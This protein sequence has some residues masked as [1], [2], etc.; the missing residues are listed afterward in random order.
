MSAVLTPSRAI[1]RE[2]AQV[3]VAKLRKVAAE[4]LGALVFGATAKDRDVLRDILSAWRYA[5]ST[6]LR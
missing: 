3:G 4:P 2:H 6:S 1:G 5:A